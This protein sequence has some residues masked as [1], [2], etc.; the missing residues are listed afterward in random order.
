MAA[1]KF[2]VTVI[3]NCYNG[4]KYLRDTI[5]S[6]K[7]QTYSNFELIF[8][9]N[10][11]TDNSKHIFLEYNDPRFK[12]FLSENHTNLPTARNL[13]LNKAKGDLISFI[14]S[15]DI[16]N[17]RKL[18]KQV[19][20]FRDS[21]VSAVFADINTIN[22]NGEILTKSKFGK[23][24]N[25]LHWSNFFL[26]NFTVCFSSI[27]FRKKDMNIFNN[28]YHIIYD[29]DFIMKL[30]LKKKI[31]YLNDTLTNYRI[32]SKNESLL[33]R[34]LEFEE[35]LKWIQNIDNI[36]NFSQFNNFIY[37]KNYFYYSYYI[38]SHLKGVDMQKFIFFFKNISWGIHKLKMIV[39]FCL[40]IFLVKMLRK[41]QNRE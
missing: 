26:K 7:K 35:K 29:F 15:D 37:C 23:L 17:E 28:K 27:I 21:T 2:L 19:Y 10:K 24:T 33:N 3:I 14:D 22:S 5:S 36:K 38:N 8:W 4:E 11:S 18:E 9:D 12:Y 34:N 13:S 39:L 16:W 31:I 30:S 20:F 6:V 1:K 25:K 40:P 32:H 41:K